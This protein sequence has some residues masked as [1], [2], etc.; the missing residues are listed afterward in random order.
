M[1][2]LVTCAFEIGVERAEC[3]RC[4]TEEY[5]ERKDSGGGMYSRLEKA[6]DAL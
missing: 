2:F 1:W 5:D 4:C 6:S 3:L